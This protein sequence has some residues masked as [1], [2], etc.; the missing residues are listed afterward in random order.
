VAT[1]DG[2]VGDAACVTV[3]VS[4][5]DATCDDHRR[6]TGVTA[7]AATFEAPLAAAL[8]PAARSP[9]LAAETD[10]KL[11]AAGAGE[12]AETSGA[13]TP[14]PNEPSPKKPWEDEP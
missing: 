11:A 8:C 10:E 13:P 3:W 9:E 14:C 5:W 1:A 12:G 7:T 4:G 2:W 6:S